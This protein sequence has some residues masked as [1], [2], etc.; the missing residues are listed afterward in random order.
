MYARPCTHPAV[1]AVLVVFLALTVSYAAYAPPAAAAPSA[2]CT[3]V[4]GTDLTW[5]E[6]TNWSGCS[7]APGTG[8]DVYIP[9]VGTGYPEISAADVT[10]HNLTVD[11]GAQLTI[12][13]VTLTLDS[14]TLA[15][16]GTVTGTGTLQTQ[17]TA[18]L[19]N[20]GAI[21]AA[22]E[23][24]GGTTTAWGTFA[25]TITVDG[26]A[27]LE[28]PDRGG[29]PDL[30]A[31]ADVTIDG[32]LSG[33]SLDSWVDFSGDTLINNGEVSIAEFHFCKTGAQ[34]VAGTG[35][36]TGMRW[37]S[38]GGSS[39][40]SLASD[41]SMAPASIWMEPGATLDLNGYQ[42]ALTGT[43]FENNNGST[44]QVDGSLVLSGLTFHNNGGA[45]V[46][47]SGVV[48]AYG[49]VTM[50]NGAT[51]SAALEV[52]DGTTTAWG[53]F[54]GTITVDVGAELYVDNSSSGVPDLEAHGNLTVDGTLTLS[55]DGADL[56]FYGSTFD[57]A[58]T[59]DL[60]D[61]TAVGFY[62]NGTQSLAG[63]GE[64]TGAGTLEVDNGSVT[65]LANDVTVAVSYVTIGSYS[66]LDPNGSTLTFA[67]ATVDVAD[68]GTLGGGGGGAVH[69]QGV[70]SIQLASL[71]SMVLPL[72]VMDGTTSAYG[73]FGNTIAVDAGATLNV[74]DGET[75]TLANHMTAN[76]DL[77]V[78]GTLAISGGGADITF[79]GAAFDNSGTVTGGSIYFFGTGAQ[80]IAGAGTWTGSCY[81][82]VGGTSSVSLASDVS[83]DLGGLYLYPGG[84]STLDL[85][86]NQLT[87]TGTTIDSF[88][89]ILV[90]SPLVLNDVTMFNEGGAV[91][92]GSG[93]VEIHGSSYISNDG[94]FT[95]PL[96]IAGGTTTYDTGGT[97][98]YHDVRIDGGAVWAAT[99]GVTIHVTG[100]WTNDGTFT[101]DGGT[102]VFDGGT[103]QNLTL[104]VPTTFANLTVG[105]GTTL[106]EAVAADNATVSGTLSNQG[107][108][109]K[110]QAVSGTGPL[111]FG[112]TGVQ[113]NVTTQGTL[114]NVQVD[115]VDSNHPSATTPLQTGRYW[116]MAVTGSGYTVNLTLPHDDLGDPMACRYP[117]GLGGYGWDCGRTSFTSGQVT[118]DGVGDLLDAW[119]VGDGAGPTAIGSKAAGIHAS[120]A[121][122]D[123]ALLVVPALSGLA[124]VLMS[125]KA[126]RRRGAAAGR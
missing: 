45:T 111:A 49:A 82:H 106:V 15:N 69:T 114:T 11:A 118:R 65:L 77:T 78:Y 113:M 88:G 125:R 63:L 60:G 52:A 108:L 74:P 85:S 1:L 18:A 109:R 32:T 117:G 28:V 40:V 121:W 107:V 80:S 76:G 67:D 56:F 48:Y 22:V 50:D 27:V 89:T 116:A 72:E 120:A 5:E 6:P 21:V 31:T 24:A 103:E 33:N 30:L 57:N 112:L 16:S 43:T 10:I 62:A 2:T 47:G 95:A 38:I 105:A 92:G 7:A 75:L 71:A 3:W 81:W 14:G 93:V 124:L 51:F 4:G 102:V 34:S 53:T 58:G 70:T 115:R 37:V 35:T 59:V 101:A 42:L 55:G 91:V 66:A 104:N 73:A 99:T 9:V 41:V 29:D 123:E 12:T 84:D 122:P 26:G 25:G 119:A 44:V 8:D 13:G 86:G 54:D 17:G 46:T 97:S 79:N 100:D 96:E 39:T 87:L 61:L 36:W 110:M 23:I 90:N 64:W 19:H 20:D 83:A 94:T 126:A 98:T 68:D